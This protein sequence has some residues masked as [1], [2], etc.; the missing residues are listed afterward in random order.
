MRRSA[1]GG[2][3]AGQ[4]AAH[5]LVVRLFRVLSLS[6]AIVATNVAALA[7][8]GSRGGA[9]AAV[10]AEARALLTSLVAAKTTPEHGSV[11]A[12]RL[13]ADRFLAA[14]WP[15]ADVEVVGGSAKHQNV[16]VRW[17]ATAPTAK[18]VLFMSHLDVVDA[19]REDWD[20]DPFV[21]RERDGY[22]YGRGVLDDKAAVAGWTVGLIA[23]RREGWRPS[24]DIVLILTADEETTANDGTD[25]L[26]RNRAPLFD[27]DFAINSDASG[28]E[29]HGGKVT[30]FSVDVAEKATARFDLSVTNRGGHSSR[31]RADNAIYALA[32]ALVRLDGYVF[33]AQL[34][35]LQRAGLSRAAESAPAPLADALRALQRDPDDSAA[36]RV[37]ASVAHLNALV[38]T[39]CVATELAAGHAANALPQRASATVNCRILPGIPPES[40]TAVLREVVADTAVHITLRPMQFPAAPPTPMRDDVRALLER[41]V[42]ASWGP[43]ARVHGTLS[44]GASDGSFTRARG[45]PTYTIWFTPLDPAD[46]R[47]H[48][49]D[50]RILV[51]SFEESVSFARTVI[52]EAAGPAR[53]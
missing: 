1:T 40:V 33:P 53:R 22:L 8:Q 23:L 2:L 50:E 36:G 42:H 49:R 12:A 7:A 28:P 13:V 19:K 20:T 46:M 32:R 44:L 17:R 43:S 27:V 11:A 24:R 52:R 16:V 37:V 29:L 41:A 47:A 25:W 5:V 26:L 10:V 34:S 6:A 14:G 38:R 39:T 3:A 4:V 51:K 31:P 21:L 35:D 30:A 9:D 18:P 15:A 45:I 48:G